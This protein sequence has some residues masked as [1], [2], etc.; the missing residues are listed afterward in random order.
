MSEKTEG[1]LAELPVR[2][3]LALE[4]R[5]LAEAIV[6]DSLEYPDLYLGGRRL[7]E[8]KLACALLDLWNGKREGGE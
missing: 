2:L 5:A 4:A 1:G 8:A 6:A 3:R 7:R